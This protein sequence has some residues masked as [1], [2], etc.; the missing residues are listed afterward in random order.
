[1]RKRGKRGEGQR[2]Q[3][4]AISPYAALL[5]FVDMAHYLQILNKQIRPVPHYSLQ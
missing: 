2:I 4:W 5:A 3:A 1:M